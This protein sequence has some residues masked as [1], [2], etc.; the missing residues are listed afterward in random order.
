MTKTKTIIL[1]MLIAVVAWFQACQDSSKNPLPEL[2]ANFI[3]A[4]DSGLTTTVFGFNVIDAMDCGDNNNPVLFRFDWDGDGKWDM[5]YSTLPTFEHRYYQPGQYLATMEAARVNGE[6][7]TLTQMIN[8]E[9]GYSAPQ[10]ILIVQPDSANLLTEFLF[11]GSLT[12]DDEDSL[13][14]LLFRWD[15]NGDNIWDT[16]FQSE[17]MITHKFHEHQHFIA[18]MEVKDTMNLISRIEAPVIVN[19]LNGMINPIANY[20]CGHCTV[21]DEFV[22]DASGSYEEGKPEAKLS[23]SWDILNDS[24][25]EVEESDNTEY[26]SYFLLEGLVPVKLRVTSTNG[27][28]MDT[29]LQIEV[30]EKNTPPKAKLTIGCK[31]GNPQTQFYF[32]S[33]RSWDRDESMMNL[34][35]RWDLDDD[36]LWDADLNDQM[37]VYHQ[38][39]KPGK[40]II[41]MA[42]IDSGDKEVQDIDSIMVFEGNHETGLV[43][44]KRGDFDQEYGTVKI[45]NQWWMQENFNSEFTSK[46]YEV[47]KHCYQ[48]NPANCDLNG[49]LYSYSDITFSNGLC[50]KGWRVPK[51]KDWE[52]LMDNL[53]EDQIASLLFGGSGEFHIQL[54]GYFDTNKGYIGLGRSTH[55]WINENNASGVPYAWYFNP[56]QGVNQKFLVGRSYKFYVRCIKE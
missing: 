54:A 28:Y 27:L 32:H 51:V 34:R 13:E 8:V 31:V 12:H 46:M 48:N 10:P 19:L 39:D 50:P 4:P 42:I 29:L 18:V 24:H 9:Q 17:P 47:R 26:S 44:D 55:F 1:L 22:F 41:R 37:N 53:G 36:G 23:Y 43:I 21:E 5:M 25:W 52:T 30:H 16:E 11:D 49:G 33:R 20:S 7:D 38:Y 35:I 45:G 3:L 56:S 15:F 14:T 6:T 2:I 40:Y